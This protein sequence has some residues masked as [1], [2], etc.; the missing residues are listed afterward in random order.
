MK[1]SSWHFSQKIKND[2]KFPLAVNMLPLELKNASLR[3]CRNRNDKT[4]WKT[5]KNQVKI[6]GIEQNL[7][8]I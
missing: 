5:E 2:S 7:I 4:S 8:L 6:L 1:Y 3:K